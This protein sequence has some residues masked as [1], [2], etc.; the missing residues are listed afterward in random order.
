[1][2]WWGRAKSMSI[3]AGALAGA[4]VAAIGLTLYL[5]P[6]TS[7]TGD[8]APGSP[9]LQVVSRPAET[10]TNALLR[11]DLG[12]HACLQ[13]LRTDRMALEVPTAARLFIDRAGQPHHPAD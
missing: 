2:G 7:F 3:P 4:V 11:C 13:R 10:V 6:L 1:M 5:I 12:G 8:D 9:P